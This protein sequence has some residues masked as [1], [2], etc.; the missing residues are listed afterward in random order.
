MAV[1]KQSRSSQGASDARG[2][3]VNSRPSFIRLPVPTSP[4]W[5]AGPRNWVSSRWIPEHLVLPVEFDRAT[6]TRRAAGC[7]RRP[8]RRCTILFWRS[9]MPRRHQ[10]YPA[11]DRNLCRAAAQCVRDRQGSC[12]P[13]RA[14]RGRFIFGVGIGW[15]EEEFEAVGMSFADRARRTSEYLALMN[16]L[17]TRK[18]PTFAGRTVSKA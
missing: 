16:Q 6:R 9:R 2:E 4:V 11:C 10:P 1:D 12:E 8:I 7:P 18:E 14:F 5:P 13:R 15:L 17:W 3:R